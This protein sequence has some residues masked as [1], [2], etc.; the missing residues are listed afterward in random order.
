MEDHPR[1]VDA[2]AQEVDALDCH[3]RCEFDQLTSLGRVY[4]IE[5]VKRGGPGPDLG[6]YR[7]GSVQADDIDLAGVELKITSSYDHPTRFEKRAAEMLPKS[8]QQNPPI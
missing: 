4:R 6:E 7:N 2:D 3:Q 5:R 1:A 8:P